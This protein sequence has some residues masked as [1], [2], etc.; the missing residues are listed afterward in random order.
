[1][2]PPK[3]VSSPSLSSSLLERT[4]KMQGVVVIDALI[5]EK[6]DV[7][8]MKV[9]SGFPRLTE[10]AMKALHTWK[11]EPARLNGQPIAM[12]T[13]VSVNFRLN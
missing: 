2:Q 8:D 12:R 10:V 6:G 3:L 1:V 11:F 7:I 4:G 5:D 9:I 13:K